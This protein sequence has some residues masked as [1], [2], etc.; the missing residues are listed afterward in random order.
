MLIAHEDVKSFED[1]KDKTI[2]IAPPAQRGYWPWL[3]AKYGFTDAQTRPYTFNIQPF[4][5]DKNTVQQG[6]LRPSRSPSQKAGVKANAFL[7]A[8]HG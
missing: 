4:F 5:A 1:M 2:L 3:K 7:L 6:Y 8:D